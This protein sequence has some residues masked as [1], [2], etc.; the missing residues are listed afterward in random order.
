MISDQMILVTFYAGNLRL[1]NY[2][3]KSLL[4]KIEIMLSFG[5]LTSSAFVNRWD[6]EISFSNY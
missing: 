5:A 6:K 2:K 1:R 4:S 3:Y